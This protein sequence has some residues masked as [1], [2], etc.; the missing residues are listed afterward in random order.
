MKHQVAVMEHVGAT[1]AEIDW[2]RKQAEGNYVK[3]NEGSKDYE[4][5]NW[6][7]AVPDSA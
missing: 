5:R 6:W 4:R 7:A 2:A 1:K 3:D